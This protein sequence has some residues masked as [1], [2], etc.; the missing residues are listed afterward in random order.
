MEEKEIRAVHQR[1][2]DEVLASLGLLDSLAKG[3]LVC[4]VCGCK[5]TRENIGTI[6]RKD[7]QLHVCCNKLDCLAATLALVRGAS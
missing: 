2:L 5:V 4:D 3:E 6:F 7:R 1:N